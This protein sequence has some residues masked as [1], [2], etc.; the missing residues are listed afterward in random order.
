MIRQSGSVN[1]QPSDKKSSGTESE[2]E[3]WK[4]FQS[5]PNQ[6]ALGFVHCPY[7]CSVCN[8]YSES[9]KESCEG[10][11]MWSKICLDCQ[12]TREKKKPFQLFF[13]MEF[14][15]HSPLSPQGK[16]PDKK[17]PRLRLHDPSHSQCFPTTSSFWNFSRVLFPVLPPSIS[18]FVHTLQ[19]VALFLDL[20]RVVI[21]FALLPHPN[22]M[23]S[24][25]T[26]DLFVLLFSHF[27]PLRA[28]LSRKSYLADSRELSAFFFLSSKKRLGNWE[29]GK[30]SSGNPINNEERP[31]PPPKIIGGKLTKLSILAAVFAVFASLAFFFRAKSGKWTRSQI[32]SAQPFQ[33]SGYCNSRLAPGDRGEIRE[34]ED[35]KNSILNWPDRSKLIPC[36]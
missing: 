2:M 34:E 27:H 32:R 10:T 1:K 8:I 7:L 12:C 35:E 15:S 31:F 16:N 33:S 29:K 25:F 13:F 36:L 5:T 30:G 14:S 3:L 22:W 28:Y 21:F 19:F 4:G 18:P 26:R 23:G 20:V 17:R 6:K 11:S 24:F 9:T